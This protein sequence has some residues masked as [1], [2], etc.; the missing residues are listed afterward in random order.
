[1]ADY[2]E[3]GMEESNTLQQRGRKGTQ[4]INEMEGEQKIF[5]KNYW[6]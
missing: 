4:M 1:M 3:L 2:A 5:W 6:K